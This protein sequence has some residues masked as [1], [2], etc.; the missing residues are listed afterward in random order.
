MH[1][2][3]VVPSAGDELE[4]LCLACVNCNLSKSDA[5]LARD[6]VSSEIVRLFNPRQDSWNDHFKWS[7]NGIYIIGHS[8]I[9]RATIVRLKMNQER[10]VRARQIWVAAG[11]H[12]PTIVD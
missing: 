6:P 1:A 4:N 5:I 12:P 8:T 9:G 10:V 2:D 11:K 7:E 3:H